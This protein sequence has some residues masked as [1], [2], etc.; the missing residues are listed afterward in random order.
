MPSSPIPDLDTDNTSFLAYY[1]VTDKNGKFNS[2][3][4]QFETDMNAR[5]QPEPADVYDNGIEMKVNDTY[6]NNKIT[7][8]A[9]NENHNWVTAHLKDYTS[10]NGGTF[11]QDGTDITDV[12]KF[13]YT[14]NK[15]DLEGEYGLML[16]SDY[17]TGYDSSQNSL[18]N[19]IEKALT[20]ASFWNRSNLKLENSGIYNYSVS[21][22]N[23]K[24]SIFGSHRNQNY[25]G[26]RETYGF[27]YTDNTNIHRAYFVG[28]CNNK[29]RGFDINMNGNNAYKI[30]EDYTVY[31]ANNITEIVKSDKD[32][33]FEFHNKDIHKGVSF[34]C[35]IVWS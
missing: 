26:S 5:F 6:T 22:P 23:Q 20:N 35:I 21:D 28:S 12:S 33:K 32:F 27:S 7:L 11:T 17:N 30:P 2:E 4:L 1:Q 10:D 18:F 25:N 15:S 3:Q 13:T 19:L 34:Y 14:T 9:G 8:R 29:Y 31:F 24:T 16:W